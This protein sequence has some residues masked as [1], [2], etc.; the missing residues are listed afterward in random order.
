[1]TQMQSYIKLFGGGMNFYGGP[2]DAAQK[3]FAKS[4]GQKTQRRVSKFAQQIAH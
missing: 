4:A 1:M 2:G 3:I